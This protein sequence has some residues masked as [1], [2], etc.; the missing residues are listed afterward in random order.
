MSLQGTL[1]EL[2]D[3]PVRRRTGGRSRITGGTRSSP[4]A[5]VRPL[6][7]ADPV[8]KGPHLGRPDS[9]ATGCGLGSATLAIA[10]SA[11]L[12]ASPA[13]ADLAAEWADLQARCGQA[14][15]LGAP[16][17][18]AGLESRAPTITY[19][20]RVTDG[21]RRYVAPGA[22]TVSGR[23]VPRGIWA[24][25]DG[26]LEMRV[27]EMKTRPGTRTICEIVPRRDGPALTAEEMER[28][29]EGYGTM[30]GRAIAGGA[31]TD[32]ALRSDA[33]TRRLGMEMIAANP[34]GCPIIAS[35]TVTP[36]DGYVRSAVSEKAGVPECGGASLV[37]RAKTRE[38]SDT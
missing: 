6:R 18:V 33:Q 3:G 12:S 10:V 31:W 36:E 8:Q 5:P 16:L 35:L 4:A 28:L 27:I 21:T 20:R 38:G 11:F 13:A 29:T 30:R 7:L 22:A 32:A 1:F 9:G 34:R 17:D 24:R 23:V 37:T 19:N 25:A 14:V 26:R 2:D 15:S